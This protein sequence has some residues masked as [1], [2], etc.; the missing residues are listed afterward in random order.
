MDAP[1]RTEHDAPPAERHTIWSWNAARGEFDALLARRCSPDTY[2][3]L[4][5]ATG[6]SALEPGDLV[7]CELSDGE[8]LVS[9]RVW[10]SRLI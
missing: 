1:A 7:R 9:D 10:R 2:E 8:L 5:A 4:E 3:V 6:S